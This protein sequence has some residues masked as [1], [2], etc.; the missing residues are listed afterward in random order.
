MFTV[1]DLPEARLKTM[2]D[3]LGLLDPLDIDGNTLPALTV[4]LGQYLP[5]KLDKDERAVA[6]IA[7]GENNVLDSAFYSDTN[8]VM[9]ISG[10]EDRSDLV[11][12]KLLAYTFNET[13]VKAG[14]S[15]DGCVFGL[16]PTGV[17][18]P[19]YEESGRVAFEVSTRMLINRQV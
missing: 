11:N 10:Q 16:I 13:I 6:I 1:A 17:Q 3:E 14:E 15:S 7:N 19:F 4:Q 2:L 18:G 5:E 8:A 12:A 9:I